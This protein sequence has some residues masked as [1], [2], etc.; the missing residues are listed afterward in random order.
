MLVLFVSFKPRSLQSSEM[1]HVRWLTA[2]C[3]ELT[4]AAQAAEQS[5]SVQ[6]R[7]PASHLE[8]QLLLKHVHIKRLN[9]HEDTYSHSAI[10]LKSSWLCSSAR[11]SEYSY[12]EQLMLQPQQL[13]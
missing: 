3:I 10:N 11:R 13:N 12:E 9:L 4:V 5:S 8:V 2:V 7:K 1:S 6:L